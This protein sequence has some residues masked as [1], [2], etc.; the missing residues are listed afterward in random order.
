MNSFILFIVAAL[1]SSPFNVSSPA[2]KQNGMIPAT[3][4][5]EGKN[6]NPSIVIKNVPAKTVS[7]ALIAKA[8]SFR[9]GCKRARDCGSFVSS[10]MVFFERAKCTAPGIPEALYMGPGWCQGHYS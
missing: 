9:Y 7:L 4:T 3:Y 2:F 5:C 10:A 6:I 8:G 1:T